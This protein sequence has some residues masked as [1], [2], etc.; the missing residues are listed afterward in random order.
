MAEFGQTG[1]KNI[2]KDDQRGSDPS[3]VLQFYFDKDQR[4]L[5]RRVLFLDGETGMP[6]GFHLHS[7][8][9]NA[10]GK[11]VEEVCLLRNGL[12]ERCPLCEYKYHVKD[13]ETGKEK[14][15]SWYPSYVGCYTVFDMGTPVMRNGKP[16]LV[17]VERTYKG[18]TYRDQW[19]RKLLLLKRG[20]EKRPGMLPKI[21]EMVGREFGEEVP[22]FKGVIFD[23]V[24]NAGDQTDR[25]G[26]SW[27]LLKKN[28]DQPVRL[29]P[30]EWQPYCV[31][32]GMTD[33]EREA[34]IKYKQ[35]EPINHRA[36]WKEKSIVQLE[37]ILAVALGHAQPEDEGGGGDRGEG[38]EGRQ[39]YEGTQG[40]SE[41]PPGW[42]S[43]DQLPQDDSDI[44][45]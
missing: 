25:V 43:S 21:T 19:R 11:R 33:E 30:M 1:S 8:Y 40:G 3:K 42:V 13:K 35:M 36:M 45:F 39:D 29:D 22:N 20:G 31:A 9:V 4:G 2:P 17:P 6:F 28:E 18:K 32:R 16:V 14:E 12:A 24:R 38:S 27:T 26:D 44:P 23:V 10:T 34:V 15:M 5:K 41:D 37:H 7:H